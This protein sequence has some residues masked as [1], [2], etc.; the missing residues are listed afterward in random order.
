M[1]ITL[2]C[3]IPADC[4]GQRLDQALA[5]IQ[6]DYSRAQWQQWIK[7]GCVS[8]DGD[9]I[10]KIRFKVVAAQHVTVDA[11][12]IEQVG[13]EAQEIPLNIIYEDEAL[14]VINKPAG[15]VVHPG[16][17]N[18][19]RTLVNAL[20]NYDPELVH[21]PRAGIVH[22]LDKD[23][24][25]ILV[26]ARNLSSHNYLTQAINERTIKREYQAVVHGALISGGTINAPIDR[27]PNHRTKMAVKNGGRAAVTHYRLIEKFTHFTHIKCELE[28]GRTHQIRVHMAH[29][30]HPIIGDPTYGYRRGIPGKFAES[31]RQYVTA[32]PRQALHAWR[33]TLAHPDTGEIMSWEAPLPEDI[34]FLLKEIEASD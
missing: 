23:T 5:K 15:L 28:S 29:I 14:L 25:G 19:D 26:V 13:W 32:F 18:P 21:V 6:P 4:T 3:H 33:L 17:G 27:H 20:L 34:C 30:S 16:A 8:I 7:D 2:E 1:N 24:S 12:L 10:T 11:E 9:V 31:L 22:R